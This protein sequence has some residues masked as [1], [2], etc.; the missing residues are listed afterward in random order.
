MK[1]SKI[2]SV[3]ILI[4]AMLCVATSAN[5]QSKMTD[6]QAATV[7]S[8][9]NIHYPCYKVQLKADAEGYL[10][11]KLVHGHSGLKIEVFGGF[12]G[13]KGKSDNWSSQS[14][15]SFSYGGALTYNYHK[16]EWPLDL[17]VRAYGEG[18]TSVTIE[19]LTTKARVMG[20]ELYV[21]TDGCK[22]LRGYAG[23][24]VDY[25]N[26]TSQTIV[27]NELLTAQIPDHSNPFAHGPRIRLEYD[28]FKITMSNKMDRGV[29]VKQQRSVSLVATGKYQWYSID[30]PLGS[31]LKMERWEANI[32][33]AVPIF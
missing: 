11:E 16:K 28:I 13:L 23:Y 21:G 5:A 8:L 17:M 12:A 15:N 22:S 26:S 9:G 19:G 10:N 20:A 18:N 6:Q 31:T 2:Y 27:D 25:I 14:D 30:E 3:V 4:V 7:A 24:G 29:R 33:I 1:T 32:G